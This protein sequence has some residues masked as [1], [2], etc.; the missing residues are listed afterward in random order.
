MKLFK[1]VV[2]YLLI[3][4]NTYGQDCR[5]EVNV[6]SDIENTE[7]YL[8]NVKVGEGRNVTFMSDTGSYVLTVRE[9]GAIW[10]PLIFSDT[11]QINDCGEYNFNYVFSSVLYLRSE[12]IDAYVFRNDSLLG[13][14]PLHISGESDGLR[15]TKPG[16][17]DIEITGNNISNVVRLEETDIKNGKSFY[18]KSLFKYLLG[19][20]VVLGGTTA[21]FKLEADKRFERYQI[22]GSES[23]LDETRRYD[24][25]SGI[26]FGALQ[27]N[28]GILLYYF[29]SE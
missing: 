29:L 7:Y 9:A 15:I 8:D 19:G 25:I 2:L 4:F 10:N 23:L 3:S 14:T 18:K 1:F 21:Y 26:T 27:I 24:L 22:T 17:R 16:Y 28:F 11:V 6:S 20:L 13:S 12:P 5:A